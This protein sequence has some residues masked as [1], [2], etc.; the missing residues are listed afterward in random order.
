[1]RRACGGRRPS[2]LLEQGTPRS[3]MFTILT[4]LNRS[5]SGVAASRPYSTGF[6]WPGCHASTLGRG[7]VARVPKICAHFP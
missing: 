6:G 5:P 7:L 2:P 1:M 4:S 3:I